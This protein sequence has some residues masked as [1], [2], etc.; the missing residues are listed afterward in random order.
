VQPSRYGVAVAKEMVSAAALAILVLVEQVVDMPLELSLFNLAGNT[1]SVLAVAVGMLAG[2][3]TSLV[4][5]SVEVVS[6]S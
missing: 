5:V 1:L 6:L 3:P 4:H 2:I